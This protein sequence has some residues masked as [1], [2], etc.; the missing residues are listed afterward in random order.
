MQ[1]ARH[2]YKRIIC[3]PAAAKLILALIRLPPGVGLRSVSAALRAAVLLE[4]I[5]AIDRT[6]AARLE[7]HLSR[8]ATTGASH[9]IHGAL[10]AAASA[11]LPARPAALG[12][13]SG[14]IA[15]TFLGKKLLLALCENELLATIPAGQNLVCQLDSS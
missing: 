15:E 11:R 14:F 12:A 1:D 13:A 2:A 6:I 3:P 9:L 10:A 5:P 8:L 4:A 7:R